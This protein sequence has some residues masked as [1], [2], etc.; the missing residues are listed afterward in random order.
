MAQEFASEVIDE[1]LHPC[2]HASRECSHAPTANAFVI[3]C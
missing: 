3:R 2:N 1:P